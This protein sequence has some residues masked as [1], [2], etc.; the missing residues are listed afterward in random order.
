MDAFQ[1]VVV[2]A[3]QSGP[4]L[5]ARLAEAGRRVALI[6]KRRL[7]GTCVNDGCIPTKTLVAS[8]RAAWMVREAHRWGVVV[9]PGARVELA[10]VKARKDEVVQ[11]SLDSLDTWLRGTAGLTLI[12]GHARFLSPTEI[13]VG[14]RRLT[15]ERFFLNTGARAIV[16]P[17]PGLAEVALTNTEMMDLIVLPEHLVVVGGGVVAVEFAQMYRR[18]GSRVTMLLRGHGLLSREDEDVAA[19]VTEVLTREGIAIRTGA[20]VRQVARTTTGA[21]LTLAG[22][23]AI[24]ATHVL[25]ATGRAPS[26]DH[27]GLDAAGVVTD[28]R[29]YVTVDGRLRTNVAHIYAL[30]DV[31]G[32]GAFTHTSYNDFEVVAANLLDGASRS[33]DDRIFIAGIYVDPPLGRVGMTEREARA[34]GRRVLRGLRPMTRVGRA[35]ERGETDGFIK[36]LVDAD[37]RLILGAAI[38]G[39]EGDEA[40][41][42]IAAAMTARAPYTVLREAV[43]AHPT[44]SELIPTVL[45]GLE[46]LA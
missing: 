41:H 37:S 8:A 25:V 11:A 16:P 10:Q 7:G 21:R 30:G 31:N 14:D 12:D 40:V 38:L 45:G 39:I 26:S 24:E 4:F 17:T 43:F 36:I 42:V 33:I 13:E 20:E 27:L 28:E 46:P 35:K 34:S 44:V 19:V 3:G 18:F 2:G 6:E 22:G 32:R 9:P 23:E 15:A 29:G 5:A 1:D